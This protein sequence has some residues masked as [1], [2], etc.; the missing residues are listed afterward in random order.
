[1][2]ETQFFFQNSSLVIHVEITVWFS[3]KEY[4]YLMNHLESTDISVQSSCIKYKEKQSQMDAKNKVT[5]VKFVTCE[6]RHE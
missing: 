2:L 1:M 3:N 4:V 5:T 6:I